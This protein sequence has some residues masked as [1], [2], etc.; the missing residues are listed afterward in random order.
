MKYLLSLVLLITQISCFACKYCQIFEND[1]FLDVLF[2]ENESK[3]FIEEGDTL[4]AL[5]YSNHHACILRNQNGKTAKFTKLAEE[6]FDLSTP[7]KHHREYS[8]ALLNFAASKFTTDPTTALT[9]FTES[10]N[11]F[12]N[13]HCSKNAFYSILGQ[14]GCSYLVGKL[15][16]FGT[17]LSEAENLYINSDENLEDHLGLYLSFSSIKAS[18]R[19][20]K[21]SAININNVAIDY[22]LNKKNP[23]FENII[24]N[25]INLSYDHEELG[26]NEFAIEYINE[27]E[28]ISREKSLNKSKEHCKIL[29]NKLLLLTKMEES[30]NLLDE[31]ESELKVCIKENENSFSR[32]EKIINYFNTSNRFKSTTERK[33]QIY[34]LIKISTT[35]KEINAIN[36]YLLSIIS[37][38]LEDIGSFL[39]AIQYEIRA[40]EI[41][42]KG[43]QLNY[44]KPG[45]FMRLA[46]LYNL[47][48]QSNLALA[49]SQKAIQSLAPIDHN[50]HDLSNPKT[51][52][53]SKK[54]LS[55]KSAKEKSTALYQL[56]KEAPKDSCLIDALEDTNYFL[57]D[58]IHASQG[59]ILSFQSKS[60]LH[61]KSA[62]VFHQISNQAFELG[63][64]QLLFRV[65]E[66]SKSALL[67]EQLNNDKSMSI[68]G[69]PDSLSDK[70]N[71]TKKSLSY[72]QGQLA[73]QE[74]LTAKQRDTIKIA[75]WKDKIV[76]FQSDLSKKLEHIKEFFPLYSERSKQYTTID[77]QNIKNS[78]KA[79]E[80]ILEYVVSDSLIFALLISKE[81]VQTAKISFDS[82]LKKEIENYTSLLSDNSQKSSNLEKS[83]E[84]V[85]AKLIPKNFQKT[86]SRKEKVTVVPDGALALLP[87]ELANILGN[88]LISIAP[89][90]YTY[91]CSILKEERAKKISNNNKVLAFAP[92]FGFARQNGQRSCKDEELAALFCGSQEL[93][94]IAQYHRGD[95]VSAE[96]A[97]IA[98][99]ESQAPGAAIIHLATHACAHKEDPFENRVYF[100]DGSLTTRELINMDL[101]A[102]LAVLS[103]CETGAGEL[104]EGEGVMSLSR[105]FM[106]GGIPSVVMSLWSVDDCSTAKL[107]G[108]F[109][110]HLADELPKDVALQRAKKDFLEEATQRQ[111]HPYYWAG[112]VLQGDCTPIKNTQKETGL[113]AWLSEAVGLN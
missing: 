101:S 67:L 82:S 58:L 7:F 30:D 51:D 26:E 66:A 23:D 91:S 16:S 106:Y 18:R 84:A 49:A 77:L 4:Q 41:V 36:T 37:M 88:Y 57:L 55:I 10:R 34:N 72:Y 102:D 98:E 103:A 113:L 39:E 22:E 109:Y 2:L 110:R 35:Y 70:L 75:T 53:I 32:S 59:E 62:E 79:D 44:R 14:A 56:I 6:N 1:L 40:L 93:E 31:I 69:V 3:C 87:F 71:R 60:Q 76:Y 28:K 83:A 43:D 64:K 45:R 68:S 27:A 100:S 95:F 54:L 65:A 63:N 11:N 15:N 107:M 104:V 46:K 80:C 25:Y 85:W 96:S 99:F 92:S 108:N 90:S 9:L 17:F 50:L 73:E 105:S 33:K 74:A 21:E 8:L 38:Y 47:T 111:R 81:Q 29:S 5:K 12:E 19:G 13:H 97:S 86:I 20:D 48:G 61:E 42:E 78:L 52:K 89:V 112:F 24:A 94:E